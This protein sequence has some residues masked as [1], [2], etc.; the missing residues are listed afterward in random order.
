MVAHR[1]IYLG[2]YKSIDDAITVRKG[3]EEKYFRPLEEKVKKIKR[4]KLKWQKEQFI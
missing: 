1:Q 3:A 2:S 4:E